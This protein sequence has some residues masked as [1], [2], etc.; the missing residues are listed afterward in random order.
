MHSLGDE[1]PKRSGPTMCPAAGGDPP[2]EWLPKH[3][4]RTVWA[5]NKVEQSI[6]TRSTPVVSRYG[7]SLGVPKRGCQLLNWL[8]D[9]RKF[10]VNV[11][12]AAICISLG[13][14]TCHWM[15]AA[16][17]ASQGMNSQQRNIEIT[18][19]AASRKNP[20]SSKRPRSIV[21][22]GTLLAR[23]KLGAAC[24]PTS[25]G[26]TSVGFGLPPIT[27]KYYKTQNSHT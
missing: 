7:M 12:Q 14:E 15:L 18:S 3:T 22:P 2:V 21:Q 1:I 17:Q 6:Q 9:V 24:I 11:S 4:I 26:T 20:T 25:R 10:N 13:K 23:V 19:L 27:W 5:R 8:P 16:Q